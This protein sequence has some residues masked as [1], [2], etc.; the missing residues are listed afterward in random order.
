MTT[1]AASAP[2]E[3]HMIRDKIYEVEKDVNKIGL[4]AT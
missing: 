4:G 2:D 1:G 3:T